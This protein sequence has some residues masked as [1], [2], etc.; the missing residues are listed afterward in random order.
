LKFVPK[1]LPSEIVPYGY[2][3]YNVLNDNGCF[4]VWQCP[5]QYDNAYND[6]VSK[7]NSTN[8]NEIQPPT[9]QTPIGL[10]SGPLPQE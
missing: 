5:Q 4:W 2:T 9:Y 1:F 7:I 3:G 8:I 6:F 10:I